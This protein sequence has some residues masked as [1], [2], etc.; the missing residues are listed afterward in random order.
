VHLVEKLL[1]G[2]P[3]QELLND[4]RSAIFGDPAIITMGDVHASVSR[5][6]APFIPEPCLLLFVLGAL[7]IND[8]E[9][10]RNV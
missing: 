5:Q 6:Q 1:K 3:G 4:K 2:L 8:F 7:A 10:D 9:S